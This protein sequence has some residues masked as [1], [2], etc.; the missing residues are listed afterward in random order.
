MTEATTT[1]KTADDIGGEAYQVIGA[2]ADKAGLFEH[3]EVQRVLD[4]FSSGTFEG[5]VLPFNLD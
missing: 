1:P 3:P 5:E 2:L 4:Y